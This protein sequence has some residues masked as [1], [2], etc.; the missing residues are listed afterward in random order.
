MTL[1]AL[2][3]AWQAAL[4]AFAITVAAGVAVGLVA[5]IASGSVHR[6]LTTAVYLYGRAF[7]PFV[8][9]VTVATYVIQ[10]ARLAQR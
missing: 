10:R 1:P 3:P 9:I 6:D 5:A 2:R 4:V 8:V 7:A